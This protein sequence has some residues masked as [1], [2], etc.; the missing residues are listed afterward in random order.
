MIRTALY[1][2][3]AALSGDGDPSAAAAWAAAL[4]PSRPDADDDA[5][6]LCADDADSG[7]GVACLAFSLRLSSGPIF[8]SGSSWRLGPVP[9]AHPTPREALEAL[10][11]R[12]FVP[13]A[14]GEPGAVRWWGGGWECEGCRRDFGAGSLPCEACDE[15]NVGMAADDPPS[16]AALLAV[17]SLGAASLAR[18]EL[19]ADAVRRGAGLV[20]RV[21]TAASFAARH[22]RLVRSEILRGGTCGNSLAA[23]FATEENRA[24]ESDANDGRV[25]A[26]PE[27]C[28]WTVGDV[29]R[30]WGAL[31]GLRRAGVHLLAH[32][33]GGGWMADGAPWVALGAEAP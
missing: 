7:V 1:D 19:L 13:P 3:L 9:W 29:S 16:H 20:W 22:R 32:G 10:V 12:G 2:V 33:P 17:A 27:R 26:W 6:V 14:W 31:L 11:S 24:N 21:D 23:V 8:G 15:A 25:P 28:P 4:P 5:D 18:V 30:A